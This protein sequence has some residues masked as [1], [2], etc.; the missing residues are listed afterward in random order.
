MSAADVNDATETDPQLADYLRDRDVMCPSCGAPLR[1]SAAS[2]CGKCGVALSVPILESAPG[3][4]VSPAIIVVRVLA[5]LAFC[6]AAYLAYN[7][8]FNKQPAGCSG[9]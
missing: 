5:A 2:K 8:V 9:D 4:G 7:G 3:G 1:G 6:V